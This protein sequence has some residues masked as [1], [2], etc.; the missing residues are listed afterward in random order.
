MTAFVTRAGGVTSLGLHVVWQPKYRRQ[1]VGGRVARRLHELLAKTE[2]DR[3]IT[4]TSW[5][6]ADEQAARSILRARLALLA[7]AHTA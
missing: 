4:D 1:D 7:A 3:I 6:Y 2:L 5:A